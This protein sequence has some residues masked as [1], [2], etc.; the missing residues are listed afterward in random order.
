MIGVV[1]V[2]AAIEKIDDYWHPRVAAEVG[3]CQVRLS[4]IK[5]EFVWHKHE[6]EDELF[7]VIRGE[8][9]IRL[10]DGEVRLSAGEMAVIPA[11]VEHCPVAEEEVHL[12]LVEPKTTV[13][14]GDADDPRRRDVLEGIIELSVAG[15]ESRE[16]GCEMGIAHQ[17]GTSG[18]LVRTEVGHGDWEGRAAPR[19]GPARGSAG[20]GSAGDDGCLRGR[21]PC[22]HGVYSSTGG[23]GFSGG[24]ACADGGAGGDGG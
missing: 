3:N 7:W 18:N 10:R 2:A 21:C 22:V 6:H 24:T 11:G 15:W 1:N 14:T 9:L 20:D 4:R 8:L 16:R 12:A 17:R 19:S 5:G 13:N 23:A